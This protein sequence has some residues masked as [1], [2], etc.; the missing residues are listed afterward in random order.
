MADP[1]LRLTLPSNQIVLESINGKSVSEEYPATLMAHQ[2]LEIKGR[3]TGTD[4]STLSDFNGTVQ[5]ILYDAEYSTTS[6]GWGEGKQVTFEQKGSMLFSARGMVENGE[7]TINVQ[8]PSA[9]ADNYRPATLSL[10]AN[11]T[12]EGDLREASG[13]SR[14]VYAFGYDESAETDSE[15]PVIH[16]MHLN[17][18]AFTD[19]D[20]VNPE[21][22]LIA[23]ISD[24]SG[25][26]M[27]SAGVGKKMTLTIDGRTTFDDVSRYFTPDPIAT[28][29][30]MS[31]TISYPISKLSPGEHQLRLRIW[32]IDGNFTDQM[33]TCNVIEGLAPEIYEVYTTAVPATT[34]AKFYVK[35]NRPDQMLSVK[36][37][38]YNLQGTLVWSGEKEARSDMGISAPIVWNLK[39]NGG[40]RV[41]RGFYVY[42]AEVTSQG[43]KSTTASRK[44]AVGNEQ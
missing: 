30:A 29:G 19:G 34:E 20:D 9:L 41:A 23:S 39:D 11:S 44:L 22:L 4:N 6:H 21:P 5:A 10:Y 31:G 40:K 43:S 18:D 16:A 24:N 37:S 13:M 15:P 2:K 3:I 42:R 27:A 33:L 32:D 12:V 28:V 35:H 26:N 38:V 17:G 25:L 7:F 8:M 1:A 14:N 36:I